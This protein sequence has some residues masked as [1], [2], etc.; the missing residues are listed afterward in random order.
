MNEAAMYKFVLRFFCG[1]AD[2]FFKDDVNV[3]IF[4]ARMSDLQRNCR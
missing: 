3:F 4:P 2:K 1:Y